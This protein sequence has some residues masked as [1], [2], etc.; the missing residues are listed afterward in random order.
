[1][2]RLSCGGAGG[3]KGDTTPPSLMQA[4]V[5]ESCTGY[6]KN[7]GYDCDEAVL[8]VSRTLL[9]AAADDPTRLCT[10]RTKQASAC[11]ARPISTRQGLHSCIMRAGAASSPRQPNQRDFKVRPD[12][13]PGVPSGARELTPTW[14]SIEIG[15]WG[16]HFPLGLAL[17]PRHRFSACTTRQSPLSATPTAGAGSTTAPQRRHALPTQLPARPSAASASVRHRGAADAF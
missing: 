4:G 3:R 2:L 17:L 7:N 10:Q 1:L 9:E 8:T 13:V 12:Y 16:N 15:G 5:G 14:I 6:C 11:N